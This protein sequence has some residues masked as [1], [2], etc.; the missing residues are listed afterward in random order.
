MIE[1]QEEKIA[2]VTGTSTGLGAS[3]SID[4]ANKGY[5]VYATMRNL[6]KRG[7]L[8]SKAKKENVE[9]KIAKLDVTNSE[10]VKN[11]FNEVINTE[12][13][14]DLLVNNAGAGLLKPSEFVTEEEANKQFDLNFMGVMRCTNAVLPIMR[15]KQK[16]HIINISSVGGLV[17]Q[18]FNEIYCATKFAVE[19]YTEGLASYLTPNFNIKFSIIEPGGIRTEFANSVM[20]GIETYGGINNKDYNKILNRY[21]SNAQ[22]RAKQIDGIYQSS[23]ECSAEIMKIIDS[24]FIPLRLRTSKWAEKFSS[25]KTQADPDGLKLLAQTIKLSS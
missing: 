3:I 12:G 19:G 20:K 13:K 5:K 21:I 15:N 16:G 24:D 1:K 8:D 6:N 25:L 22:E 4:L 9:L 17:G 18:A 14:I 11:L 23:D 2:V 7:F 10:N